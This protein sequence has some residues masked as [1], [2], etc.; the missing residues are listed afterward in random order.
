MLKNVR[1]LGIISGILIV[2][3]ILTISVTVRFEWLMNEA[4]NNKFISMQLANELRQSSQ[5]L[6]R[7][8]RTYVVTANSKYKD[9]YWDVVKVRN[10]QKARED[11]RTVALQELMKQQGF[12]QA[13]LGKLSEA[14]TKSNGLIDR[15]TKAMHAIEGVF[16]DASGGYTVKG[17]PDANLARSLMHDDTYHRE[18]AIIMEPI[19]EFEKMM[20]TRTSKAVETYVAWGQW[21]HV[22]I[23]AITLMLAGT[24]FLLSRALKNN[25]K[26][27]VVR[28]E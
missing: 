24:F 18:I 16:A 12:T 13:E 14:A 22:G 4:H 26:S 5:D 27:V 11:G 19:E 20:T 8:A 2:I 15:E 21:L 9:M 17:E 25:I 7:L 1:A 3:L 10:G 6:T 23:L 28:L